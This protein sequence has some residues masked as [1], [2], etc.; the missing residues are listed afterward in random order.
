MRRSKR[1]NKPSVNHVDNLTRIWEPQQ[2]PGVA[3]PNSV[4]TQP[5]VIPQIPRQVQ[6]SSLESDTVG[7]QPFQLQGSAGFIPAIMTRRRRVQ[8]SLVDHVSQ[9]WQSHDRH[10]EA[11][12]SS[13]PD[14]PQSRHPVPREPQA[15]CTEPHAVDRHPSEAQVSEASTKCTRQAYKSSVDNMGD[16][17]DQM[18]EP[19]QISLGEQSSSDQETQQQ[20]RHQIPGQ[21]QLDSIE[22]HEAD[23]HHSTPQGLTSLI[24]AN[25]LII[26]DHF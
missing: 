23:S 17:M 13:D 6:L 19:Q 16:N 3:Q 22:H 4:Q 11:Q 26:I 18:Q 15:T 12:V 14:Q 7:S 20:L 21:D 24:C 5:H 2:I 1:I 9:L 10:E 8:K 25:N